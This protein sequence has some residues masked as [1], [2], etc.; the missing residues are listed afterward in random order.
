MSFILSI[1][2]GTSGTKVIIVNAAGQVV[3]KG[4]E[5][6]QTKYFGTGFVEQDPNDIYS[7]VLEAVERCLTDF[8][9]NG[10]YKSDIRAIGISNQ[11]ETFV[12]WD[13][14]GKP[15]H[16]A[17]VWQCKRSVSICEELKEKG[18]SEIVH[19]KTGLVI[20]PYFSA[21]KLIWLVQ[22]KPEIKEGLNKDDVFFGTIDSWLLYKLTD[23]KEYATD[24]TN[25]SRTLFFNIHTLEWDQELLNHFGL[26]QLQLPAVKSSS[27]YFGETTIDGLLDH[28]VPIM[29][30][31]GDSH[32]AAFGEGC[33]DS[34]T[35]KATLGTG[36]SIMM[37]IGD[38]PVSSKNGMVTTICW[39]IPSCVNYALEGV[40][41]TCG[42]TI[43]WLKNEIGLFA[44]IKATADM[45]LSV[46]DN[47][48]VY[49]VP[50]F[51]GLGSP[52]WQMDRKASITGMTFGTNKN[53]IVRTALESIPYQIKDVINAM[54]KDTKLVLKQL[55]TN[56]GLSSNKFVM[57]F[58]TDVLNKPVSKSV[59][60][61]VSALGAAYMAGLA[62]GV[63]KDIKA[64]RNLKVDKELLNPS[65]NVQKTQQWYE[66]WI[67]IIENKI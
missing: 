38:Q 52:H 29:S 13:K 32:A 7:N 15:L 18:L 41:V 65:N 20:D 62:T 58:L 56:G 21:T 16:P 54:E 45:A 39:S 17:V 63:F 47:G 27:E 23:G 2:Q 35:A 43:E 34:G 53:H 51:S 59:M 33:F 28:H 37:N 30:M 46:P 26:S 42:A 6:L 12:I 60:A 44:D 48:G 66:G 36:S 10:F 3:A 64:L 40:I 57:S 49:L 25:A 19:A 50:A 8:A 24:H 5:V 14:D 31:I 9:T 67:N 4:A 61:D 1:D 55:M 22:N 11:R